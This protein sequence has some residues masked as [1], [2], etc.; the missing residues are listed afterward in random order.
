MKKILEILLVRRTEIQNKWWDRLINVLM[1]GTTIVIAIISFSLLS[2]LSVKKYIHHTYTAYNFE[3]NYSINMGKEVG[4]IYGTYSIVCGD[5]A[6]QRSDIITPKN[7]LKQLIGYSKANP[8]SDI[9]SQLE[10]AITSGAYDQQ[11]ADEGVDL[12]WAGRPVPTDQQ[13]KERRIINLL[14]ENKDV[15]IKQETEIL[16]LSLFKD[17]ATMILITLTWFIF[18]QSII[19][20]TFAYIIYGKKK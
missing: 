10:Q 13:L 6:I 16:Y 2:D 7:T 19:Y 12:S 4:C 14:R 9:A 17:M 20:R 3:D 18:W 11:A 8:T 15:K 5:V 1:Y